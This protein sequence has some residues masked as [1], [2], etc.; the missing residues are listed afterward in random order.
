MQM[1]TI[2][3]G[4]PCRGFVT[5]NCTSP[6][7]EIRVISGA[8]KSSKSDLRSINRPGSTR[9]FR[10]FCQRLSLLMNALARTMIASPCISR[11]RTNENIIPSIV[12]RERRRSRKLSGLPAS[13]PIHPANFPRVTLC[14]IKRRESCRHF[15]MSGRLLCLNVRPR[16]RNSARTGGC[17]RLHNFSGAEHP[18]TLPANS[19]TANFFF[20]FIPRPV[21]ARSQVTREKHTRPV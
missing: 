5:L 19:R 1:E 14:F 13:M 16:S 9:E 4:R 18:K 20:L 11:G 8:K 3:R 17:I 15:M 10:R 7:S 2:P 21:L 12:C 6:V